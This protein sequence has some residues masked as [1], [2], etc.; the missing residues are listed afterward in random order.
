[1]WER[2]GERE[3]GKLK[4]YVEC[5]FLGLRDDLK[6]VGMLGFGDSFIARNEDESPNKPSGVTVRGRER[7]RERESCLDFTSWNCGFVL[8]QSLKDLNL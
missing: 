4:L 3:R 6:S 5:R 1:M 2:E 7:E 8:V